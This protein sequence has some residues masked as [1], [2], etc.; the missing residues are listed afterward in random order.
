MSNTMSDNFEL[1]GNWFDQKR[2]LKAKYPALTEDDLS[3][4]FGQKN[5][6]L[7]KLQ[8]TLK[9]TKEELVTTI[10]SL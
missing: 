7:Q 4:G 2:K 9:Q 1:K 8:T 10:E 5:E 6:M 3:F